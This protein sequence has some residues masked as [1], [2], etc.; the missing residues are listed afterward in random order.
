MIPYDTETLR[1]LNASGRAREARKF[2]ELEYGRA[3]REWA[4]REAT[5]AAEAPRARRG[6]WISAVVNYLSPR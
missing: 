1:L 6:A 4:A 2:A 3:D 5:R